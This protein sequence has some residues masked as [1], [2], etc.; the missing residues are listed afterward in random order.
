MIPEFNGESFQDYYEKVMRDFTN[1]K[2]EFPLLKV[3][4]LPTRKLK[5]IFIKGKLIPKEVLD[6]CVRKS[7]IEK[8]SIDIIAIYPNNFPQAEITVKDINGKIDWSKLPDK[9]RHRRIIDDIEYLCTHHPNG[10][11]NSI[12]VNKRSSIVLN[13][14]WK[15][16]AQYV[17]YL[18]DKKWIIAELPHGLKAATTLMREKL[19][20]V[21]KRGEYNE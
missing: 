4:M 5:K 6:N 18:K 14:A 11:I 13:N 1:L 3:T 2:K 9:H 10:E 17:K 12:H 21:E 8:N 16:Y 20:Y 7:Q 15:I 19:Y